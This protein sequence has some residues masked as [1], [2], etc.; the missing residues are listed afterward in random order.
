MPRKTHTAAEFGLDIFSGDDDLFRWFLLCL[1]FGKPIRS[2]SAVRTWELFVEKKLDTPWAIVQS[3]RAKVMW[4]INS[5]GYGHYGNSTYA[6]LVACM[7]KLISD[8]EGSLW[9]MIE[10][11][12]DEEEFV[13]RL[14]KLHGVGPRVA[15]IFMSEVEEVFARRVE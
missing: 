3:P 13:K 4:A 9:L 5:G 10:Q 14:R 15:E 2:E 6:G 12:Q 8:Y 11:S 7:T 1:L